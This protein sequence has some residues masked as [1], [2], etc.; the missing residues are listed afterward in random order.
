MKEQLFH[1]LQSTGFIGPELFLVA[2]FIILLI[3]QIIYPKTGQTVF[4]G[5]SS[6][7]FV[8]Y[9][10]LILDQLLLVQLEGSRGIYYEMLSLDKWSLF[11]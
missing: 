3:V 6:L 5:M 1:I 8:I 11:F 9:L 10:K 4:A 7:G 2:L